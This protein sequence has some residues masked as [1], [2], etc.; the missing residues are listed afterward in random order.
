MASFRKKYQSHTEHPD[1]DDPPVASA[2]VSLDIPSAVATNA[3]PV[4][5]K[6]G[7]DRA[8][9]NDGAAS[10]AVESDPV[11][12][13]ERNAIKARLAEVERAEGL[14]RQTASQQQR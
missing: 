13:A 2:P 3:A 10:P 4:D 5:E 1:R 6:P 8:P 12:E 7:D 11:K 9:S 14:V